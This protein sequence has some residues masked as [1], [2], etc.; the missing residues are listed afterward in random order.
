MSFKIKNLLLLSLLILIACS[1]KEGCTDE[2]ACNF[3][4]S[5]ESD[6][7]SCTYAEENYNCIGDCLNDDDNDGICNEYEVQGCM[8]ELA[9]NFDSLAEIE[10]DSCEYA[11][12][13]YDCDGICINDV[14][15]DGICDYSFNLDFIGIWVEQYFKNEMSLWFDSD[16]YVENLSYWNQSYTFEDFC[17]LLGSTVENDKCNYEFYQYVIPS[18]SECLDV[19]NSEN[20]NNFEYIPLN[21]D[22]DYYSPTD[23]FEIISQASFEENFSNNIL[24][25]EDGFIISDYIYNIPFETN[26]VLINDSLLEASANVTEVVLLYYPGEIENFVNAPFNE[27]YS[28]VN[29][30]YLY[31]TD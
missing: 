28:V 3:D 10:N 15:S 21:I 25:T 1:K 13:N 8:D 16:Y 24:Y 23:T 4:S 31:K 7:G 27:I 30:R 9:C 19:I 12:Q 22:C 6:D 11:E 20:E 14:N 17:T 5:A 18:S 2:L 26:Y 29:K